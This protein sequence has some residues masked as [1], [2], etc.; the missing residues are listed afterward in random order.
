MATPHKYLRKARMK[1]LNKKLIIRVVAGLA[2]FGISFVLWQQIPNLLSVREQVSA[3]AQQERKEMLQSLHSRNL[4]AIGLVEALTELSPTSNESIQGVTWIGAL[5]DQNQKIKNW[6]SSNRYSTAPSSTWEDR[7]NI[8]EGEF[9]SAV[10]SDDVSQIRQACGKLIS[11][12][13]E[14]AQFDS[15]EDQDLRSIVD[16]IANADEKYELVLNQAASF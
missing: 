4:Q 8:P 3:V 16:A 12:S 10:L 2:I 9:R 15:G 5:S 1:A 13:A 7:L 6:M 11:L 14:I